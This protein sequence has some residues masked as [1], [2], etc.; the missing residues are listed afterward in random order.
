MI[1]DFTQRRLWLKYSLLK[2]LKQQLAEVD[3]IPDPILRAE[4]RQTIRSKIETTES[5][6]DEIIRRA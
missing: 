6:I 5:Q 2:N 3:E 4:L 1:E